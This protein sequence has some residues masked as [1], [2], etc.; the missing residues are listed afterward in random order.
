MIEYVGLICAVTQCGLSFRILGC[1]A[2]WECVKVKEAFDLAQGD[3]GRG[4]EA[5]LRNALSSEAHFLRACLALISGDLSQCP[6]GSDREKGE[7]E[8]EVAKAGVRARAVAEENY[9]RQAVFEKGEAI[10]NAAN[11]AKKKGAKKDKETSSNNDGVASDPGSG[12]TSPVVSAAAVALDDDEEIPNFVLD[13]RCKGNDILEL[14][15]AAKEAEEVDEQLT[16]FRETVKDEIIATKESYMA[17][18]SHCYETETW[19][20]VLRN[21]INCL[22]AFNE[23]RDRATDA[24]KNWKGG[25]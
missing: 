1:V 19:I 2:R 11:A 25:N 5:S 17:I 15:A 22:K 21:H 14:T 10:R 20:G 4:L 3:K 12:T 8:I 9:K 13:A 6:M 23:R 18:S 7:D 24:K 16:R